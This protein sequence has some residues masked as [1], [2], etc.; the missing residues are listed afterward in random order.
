MRWKSGC[1]WINSKSV[2]IVLNCFGLTNS[3]NCRVI[4]TCKYYF[5]DCGFFLNSRVVSY[6]KK[7]CF[8]YVYTVQCT[9]ETW[10]KQYVIQSIWI[11]SLVAVFTLS[12]NNFHFDH[13]HFYSECLDWNCPCKKKEEN[14]DRNW[15][16][17]RNKRFTVYTKIR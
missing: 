15:K 3:L 1:R 4:V 10:S 17:I 2:F 6:I 8:L 14:T 9:L 13:S 11:D 7:V 5:I 12:S 16:Q